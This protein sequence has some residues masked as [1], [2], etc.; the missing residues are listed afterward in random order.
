VAF[1]AYPKA[2]KLSFRLFYQFL[3][4]KLSCQVKQIV[5]VSNFSKNEIEKY[6]PKAQGKIVVIY[7]GFTPLTR[8]NEPLSSTLATHPYFL[9]VASIEPRKNLATLIKAFKQAALPN[10]QLKIAGARAAAFVKQQFNNEKDIDFLGFQS[11]AELATLYEQSLV[12]VLP[13]LYEGFG[14]PILEAMSHHKPLL[15]ADIPVFREVAGNAALFASPTNVEAMTEA[16]QRI[17]NDEV[18]RT[19]LAKKGTDQLKLY[20][21]DKTASQMYL[22]INKMETKGKQ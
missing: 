16:I 21:W 19:E 15:L 3:S 13:S 20:S 22:L 12:F 7:N 14:L 10:V 1:F 2:F 8:A 6:L 4:K 18:L 17:N 5:T 9:T 11:D